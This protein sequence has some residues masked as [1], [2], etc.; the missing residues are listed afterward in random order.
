MCRCVSDAHVCSL[1]MQPRVCRVITA[2]LSVIYVLSFE[3]V[4]DCAGE[5]SPVLFVCKR[6]SAWLVEFQKCCGVG[7]V[8]E[9]CRV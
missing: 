3:I 4:S 8:G 5:V 9:A 1:H 6:A 2:F 7:G